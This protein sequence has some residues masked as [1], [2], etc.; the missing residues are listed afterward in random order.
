MKNKKIGFKLGLALVIVG[1]FLGATNH[2][3]LGAVDFTLNVLLGYPIS[4]CLGFAM[5]VFPGPEQFELKTQ[6]D[7]KSFWKTTS[8]VHKIVWALFL[9][10]GAIVSFALMIF[11]KLQ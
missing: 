2:I 8:I 11:Y 5:M 1:V 7:I 9:F 10:A 3:L 6:Q 4:I